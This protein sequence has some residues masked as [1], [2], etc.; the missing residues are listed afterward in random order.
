MPTPMSVNF[1]A[2][3]QRQLRCRKILPTLP[4]M[5][6][7]FSNAGHAVTI[8]PMQHVARTGAGISFQLYRYGFNRS[9]LFR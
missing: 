1:A 8:Q 7:K 3:V 5:S 9:P 2:G 6:V 4:T